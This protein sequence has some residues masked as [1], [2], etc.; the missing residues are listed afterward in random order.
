MTSIVVV[1][2]IRTNDDVRSD[3]KNNNNGR[4]FRRR[5][6]ERSH[7]FGSRTGG[8]KAREPCDPSTGRWGRH[9]WLKGDTAE[10]PRGEETNCSK[11]KDESVSRSI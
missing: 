1:F 3:A 6:P 4:E 11:S 7:C 9:R 8:E 2:L 10:T 5:S